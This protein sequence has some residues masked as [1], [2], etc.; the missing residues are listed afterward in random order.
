[1]RSQCMLRPSAISFLSQMPTLFSAWQATTQAPQ[2]VQRSRS[3]TIPHLYGLV[4][5]SIIVSTLILCHRMNVLAPP[6]GAT[7]VH[8]TLPPLQGEG[9]GGDGAVALELPTKSF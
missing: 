1:M 6:G 7:S 3:I 4:I 5:F 8:F 2:P 9:W